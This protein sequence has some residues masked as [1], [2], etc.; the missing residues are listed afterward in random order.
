MTEPPADPLVGTTVAQYDILAKIGGGGMDVV[1]AARDSK[2][3]RLVALKFLPPQWS[4]D[5]G[6]KQRFVREA[7]AASA[8][9]HRNICTIH[10]IGST[11]DGRLFIV[12]AHYEGQTLKQKLEAGP[13]DIDTAVEIAAQVAEGLAKAHAQGVVHRDIKPGNL[14]I[15]DE[16]VKILDFGL[17]KFAS[18]LQLTIEGSTLGTAAYMSPE[19]V[20][21][22]EADARSDLWALGVVLYEMLAGRVPFH[23]VYAEAVAYAIR[24]ETPASLRTQRPEVPEAL[25]QLVFRSLHKEPAVRFQS[26]RDLARAL[27]M[28]QGRTMPQDLLTEPLP[29]VRRAPSPAPPTR[30]AWRRPAA[31]IAAVLAVVAAAAYPWLTRPVERVPVV[32]APV[33]N[34]TG[35]AELDPY[36]LALTH[37]LVSEL[38]ESPN[39]RVAP[40]TQLLQIVR[41]FLTGG[42]DMSS[43]EAILALTTHTGAG[44][45]VVPTLVYENGAWRGRAEI[46]DAATGTNA[47]VYDT[48]PVASSLPK[49]TAYALTAALAREIEEHFVENGPG[50]SYTPRP[51]SARWRTLDAAKAFE[52]G[53]NAYEE[54]EYATARAA[55]AR[56]AEQ[57]ARNPLPLAWLSRASQIFRDGNAASDAAERASSLVTEATP[58]GDAL[59]VAAV[60]AEARR[61]A[62]SAEAR[63]RELMTVFP[64]E[65]AHVIELGAFQDR[66]GQSAAAIAT[67]QQALVLDERLARPDLDLCR[68]YNRT[69]DAA[70]AKQ[71][72]SQALTKYAALGARGG[73]AQTLLC[74]TDALR[75]G[76][77]AAQAEAMQRAEAALMIFQMLK[78]PYNV[79]RAYNYLAFVAGARGNR[80]DAAAFGEK[81]LAAAREAG[82]VGLQA[83]VL[84]DLGVTYDFL[85]DRARATAN[86]EQSAKLFEALGDEPGA[87]QTQANAGALRV[88]YGLDA[89]A[90][91]RAVQNALAVF[92]KL[93]DRNFEVFAAQVTAAYHRYGGRHADAER[94]LNRALAIAKERNLDDSIAY[95]TMDLARSRY[96]LGDY[97]KARELL[98]SALGDGSGPKSAE[99]RIRLGM[100]DTRLADTSS[101]DEHLRGAAA[102]LEAGGER[103]LV[104]LLYTAFGEL[105]YESGKLP[106]ARAQFERA[107]AMWVDEGPD[108]ASVE[109]RAYLGLLDGLDG[110]RAAGEAALRGSINHAQK[111]GRVVLEVRGRVFLARLHVGNRRFDDAVRLL[112]AVPPDAEQAIGRELQAQARYWRGLALAGL[113]NTDAA[114][115]EVDRARTLVEEIR[116]SLS[117]PDRGRYAARPDIRQIL[118]T[119]TSRFPASSTASARG[120][121]PRI[122][123][124]GLGVDVRMFGSPPDIVLTSGP[125]ASPGRVSGRR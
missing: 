66:S 9:D 43:R 62:P 14:M 55:F 106:E 94:E 60:L 116:A 3:G 86:Y 64:D 39:I 35:Y 20:R 73:E 71:H 26:A 99:I 119:N 101:A 104:S 51:A 109:A 114:R 40:Y 112:A 105:A 6:A 18:S 72:A 38:S 80:V 120:R 103:V 77:A 111:M 74:L 59:F 15:T 16:A 124:R 42:T 22:E 28:M 32:I 49:E 92:R 46:Q 8:T 5:E 84:M 113:G 53:V 19:Q 63:Y 110:R 58:R 31:I 13:L 27:R 65:P 96:D 21:G 95:L 1:Y 25:E 115:S 78:Y 10:D 33:V 107:A 4:H 102:D 69:N 125:V 41:Q 75:V 121:R 67:L 68:L 97:A 117:E 56:A 81:A 7:Q 61:D 93:G 87:A 90:G 24:N 122:G 45:V 23:G 57:D 12:M 50:A 76:D 54:L 11:V 85:G 88:E 118:A 52:E 37:V 47:A 83:G 30:R 108:A 91:L 17:A 34:Q 48:E 82:N 79:S 123:E 29:E 98:T 89:D 100:V 44:M 2:L 36:R 70:R